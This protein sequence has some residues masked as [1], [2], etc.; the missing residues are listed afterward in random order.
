MTRSRGENLPELLLDLLRDRPTTTRALLVEQSG[1]ARTVVTQRLQELVDLGLVADAGAGRSTGGRAPRELRLRSEAGAVVGIGVDAA[2][3]D[4]AVTDLAA[5]ELAA[6][7]EVWDVAQGPEATLTRLETLI[8][9]VI[10]ESPVSRAD[11]VGI[12]LGLPGPVEFATGRPV[13]SPVLPGW[14]GFPV[15]DWLAERFGVHVVVDNDA[16][17]MA[18]GEQRLGLAREVADFVFVKVGEGISAG[19]VSNG[20]LHRGADGGA[21]DIGHIAVEGGSTVRCR[22]GRFGCLEAYSSGAALSRQAQE[23]AQTGASP[24]LAALARTAGRPLEARDVTAG[25]LAGDATCLAL[26]DAST[27]RLGMASS[28]VVNFFNPALLV[29]GGGAARAGDILLPGIRRSVLEL[30]L[31]LATRSLQ[32]EITRLGDRAGTAGAALAVVD[33]LMR[34]EWFDWWAARHGTGR[35]AAA[36]G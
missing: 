31:P 17:A 25:A 14:S 16:N 15:R 28:G 32:I 22:C 20:R 21:G 8:W 11:V 26:L 12:G 7:H 6:H 5:R 18:L 34:A 9:Q 33:E 10:A 24:Y 19:V 2:R 1:W 29:F 13:T 27:R 35:V 23:A 4:V 36:Q 30:S 3:L